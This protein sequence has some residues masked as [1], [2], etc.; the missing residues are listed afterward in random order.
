MKLVLIEWVDSSIS[1]GG[2]H[3]VEKKGT[4]SVKFKSVGFIS[5][6]TKDSITL[7]SHVS[8]RNHPT[9]LYQCYGEITIP[10][11]AIKSIIKLKTRKNKHEEQI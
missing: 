11:C 9:A 6:K 4:R 8:E 3:A 1:P 7:I 5:A 2:W 10:R